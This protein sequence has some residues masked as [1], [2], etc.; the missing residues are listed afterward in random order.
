MV[1]YMGS[2]PGIVSSKPG[3]CG[4]ALEVVSGKVAIVLLIA[5][6]STLVVYYHFMQ[7]LTV[8]RLL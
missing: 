5:G 4:V 6:G 2:S 7:I 1:Q 3:R 8:K